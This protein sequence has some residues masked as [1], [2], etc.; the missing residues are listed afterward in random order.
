M[1]TL[2]KLILMQRNQRNMR[3]GIKLEHYSGK[4]GVEG[5]IWSLIMG[6]LE[7]IISSYNLAFRNHNE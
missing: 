6:F 4:A 2:W 5:R 3:V 7:M 1:F